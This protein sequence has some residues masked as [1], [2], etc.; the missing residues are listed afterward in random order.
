MTIFVTGFVALALALVFGRDPDTGQPPE[1]STNV[2]AP[3]A[4]SPPNTGPRGRVP[5]H[6]PAAEHA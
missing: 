6:P 4:P 1:V 2:V 5:A 3:Q